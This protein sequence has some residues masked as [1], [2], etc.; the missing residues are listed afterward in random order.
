MHG[1]IWVGRV[2]GVEPW[3]GSG[4]MGGWVSLFDEVEVSHAFASYLCMKSSP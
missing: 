2:G 1:D 4:G 3:G